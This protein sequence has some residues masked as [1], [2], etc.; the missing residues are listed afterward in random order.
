MNNL[1][2]GPFQK[3]KAG[4]KGVYWRP[5]EGKWEVQYAKKFIGYFASLEEAK[6][7]RMQYPNWA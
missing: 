2:R 5:R 4:M 3:N 1:N 6:E 7:I